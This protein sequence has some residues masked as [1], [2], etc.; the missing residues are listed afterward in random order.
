MPNIASHSKIAIEVFTAGASGGLSWAFAAVFAGTT[1][2]L[3]F[4][5]LMGCVIGHVFKERAPDAETT[6]QVLKRLISSVIIISLSTILLSWLALG[7]RSIWPWLPAAPFTGLLGFIGLFY[8]TEAKDFAKSAW[9]T[10]TQG[11]KDWVK[12]KTS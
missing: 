10:L 4:V 9:A 5:N 11:F 8:S 3:V 1:P 6:W 2:E 12:G 7:C